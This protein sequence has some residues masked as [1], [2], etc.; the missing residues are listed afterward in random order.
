MDYLK[1]AE[2]FKSGKLNR[3]KHSLVIDDRTWSH[4]SSNDSKLSKQENKDETERL[5]DIYEDGSGE[6]DIDA[7]LEALGIPVERR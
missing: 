5:R 7:I 4:I 2:D 6:E 1:I 3:E